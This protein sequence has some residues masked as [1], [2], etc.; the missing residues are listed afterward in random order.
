MS[1]ENVCRIIS[2]ND[3]LVTV[4]DDYKIQC[5]IDDNCDDIFDT[6]VVKG[7]ANYD[8]SVNS[9]DAISVLLQYG[10]ISTSEFYVYSD[11]LAMDF[12]N[13]GNVNSADAFE[14][15]SYYT[16][17]QTSNKFITKL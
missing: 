12:N 8:G 6:P 2:E 7:D 11:L 16:E 14:I 4:N 17:N 5:Y 13:D 10:R 15:F 9:A 1:N 3:V